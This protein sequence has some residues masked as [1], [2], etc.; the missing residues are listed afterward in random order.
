M[1][2]KNQMNI[3][4]LNQLK[5]QAGLSPELVAAF[6]AIAMLSAEVDSLKAEVNT[7]KGGVK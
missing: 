3:T 2:V 1:K 7:L 5:E 6:E 4:Q